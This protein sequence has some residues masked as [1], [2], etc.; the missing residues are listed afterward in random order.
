M[1]KRRKLRNYWLIPSY[2]GRYVG[3]LVA[4]CFAAMAGYGLVFYR[5]I[6][7]NY[8]T[9]VELS[10]ITDDSKFLLYSELNSIIMYLT[11]LSFVFLLVITVIGIVFS[12]KVAGPMF[13]IRSICHAINNG[14]LGR[15]IALRPGDD[16]REVVAELNRALNTLHSSKS[17]VFRVVQGDYHL[18]ETFAF[19]R[20]ITL[21]EEGKI[22]AST[23]VLETDGQSS[24]PIPAHS[25]LVEYQARKK[26]S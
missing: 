20:L 8:D 10:P 15:R 23:Q 26:S 6:R 5:F 13:K 24:T 12:H 11:V 4:S 7:E 14:N 18:N 2:Q 1:N 3:F 19:E 17:R 22:P 16:F 9:I 25:L 21:I